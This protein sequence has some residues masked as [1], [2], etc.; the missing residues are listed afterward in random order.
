MAKALKDGGSIPRSRM[1]IRHRGN[2]AWIQAHPGRSIVGKLIPKIRDRFTLDEHEDEKT[3]AIHHK[4]AHGPVYQPPMCA[5]SGD[6]EQVERDGALDGEY[7]N[8]VDEFGKYP[9]LRLR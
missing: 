7:R 5:I 2:H 1:A 8:D 9:V 6:A 3:Q 4:H